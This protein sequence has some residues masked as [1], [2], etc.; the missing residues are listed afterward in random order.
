MCGIAGIICKSGHPNPVDLE[1]SARQLAHRGPDNQDFVI[2]ENVGLVHTRLSIIDLD[3]GDQ[4]LYSNNQQQALVVNGEIYNY[5]E[6]TDQHQQ[7]GVQYL[8]HSDSETILHELQLNGVA[9]IKN[10][11][12]MFA[13]AHH[14]LRSGTLTLARDRLGIKPLYYAL[15]NDRL[16][17][18]SEIKALLPLLRNTPEINEAALIQF[19]QNQFSSGRDTIF[20]SIHRLMPGEYLTVDKNLSPRIERYW[21]ALDVE[22]R[23]LS[24]EQAAEE[25][26]PLIEQVISEHMRSDVPFGLFLSGGVD[27][28]VVLAMLHQFNAASINSYAVGFTASGMH[29]EVDGARQMSELFGTTHREIDVTP[30]QAFAQLPRV[31]WACDDLMRDYACLPTAVMSEIAAQ[32]LKVVFTGEGGDEAFAGYGRYQKSNLERRLRSLLHPGSGGF[33]TRGQLKTKTYNELLGSQLDP[34]TPSYRQPFIDAWQATPASWSNIT[35]SQYTDLI[36]ALPDNLLNKVDRMTM[37]FGLEARVPFLDHRIVEFG[38]SLPDDLKI[39][40]GQGKWFLKQWAEKHIP[41]DHLQRK[42]TGFNVPVN[43]W[44]DDALLKSLSQRLPQ[45]RAIHERFNVD[46]VKNL[47][48]AQ[49]QGKNRR[50]EIWCLMQFAIWHQLFIESPGKIPGSNENLLEWIH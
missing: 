11:H 13:F 34:T 39:K 44:L 43:D 6:L 10:L 45:H 23:N 15:E 49:S 1:E 50:R 41:R 22:P 37:S 17:F 2:R 29:H 25:F 3:G 21:T 28:A 19:L 20:K 9:G 33:R 24:Y 12:G 35:R 32:D 38:L 18:A 40:S 26:E 5:P 42:K 27:S 46:A 47:F 30:E 48:T 4:P 8:T 14:D 31:I 16:V 7:T 36:T